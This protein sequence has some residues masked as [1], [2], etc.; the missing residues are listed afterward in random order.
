MVRRTAR[1]AR[2]PA[3][4]LAV[5][6]LVLALSVH[7]AA[8]FGVDAEAA[9]PQ[10]WDLH[11]AVF[12]AVLLA[13]VETFAA[14]HGPPPGL[15]GLLARLPLAVRL[16]IALLLAYV[17]ADFFVLLP[18]SAAGEPIVEG[19]RF[20][21]NDHGSVREVSEAAFHAE[22]SGVLRLYSGV[23]VYLYFVAASVLLALRPRA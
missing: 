11:W 9:W 16:L 19:G 18:A 10:V 23:W 2:L 22:R 14:T 13:L 21:F 7:M 17:V 4:F 6:G 12:P 20:Y 8:L 1:L 15:R 5:V 3:A